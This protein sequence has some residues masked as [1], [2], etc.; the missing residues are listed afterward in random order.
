MIGKLIAWLRFMWYF[1]PCVMNSIA[2]KSND[3]NAQHSC[4]G[5]FNWCASIYSDNTQQ[6]LYFVRD[7]YQ[8]L[9]VCMVWDQQPSI[10]F[11]TWILEIWAHFSYAYDAGQET[12]PA[13]FIVVCRLYIGCLVCKT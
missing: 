13:W 2:V 3:V 5:S 6:T 12:L 10:N 4:D 1:M 9:S 7:V 8:Q 11:R